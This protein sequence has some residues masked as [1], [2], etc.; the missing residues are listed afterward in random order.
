[1]LAKLTDTIGLELMTKVA[2]VEDNATLRKYLAE[3]INN[4]PGLR[5][6]CACVSAEEALIEIPAHKPNVVL[7]DIHLPG[8]SGI[9]CTARLREKLPNLQ[10]IM[11]TVYKD[12]KMIF[13]ALKAGACG[14]V[15]KRSD[16]KEI[17]A[18]IAEV[19][20]GGAP[21]TSEIARMVVRSFM[22]SPKVSA[23]ETDQLS[24]REMEILA[25]VAEGY[26]NKEIASR[27]FISGATVRTHLMHIYEKLHV[28]CRTEAAA[29]YLR[30]NPAGSSKPA[31]ASG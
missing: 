11:L 2:I 20:A 12:I 29:K 13:Q 19:R 16:E 18:A 23:D 10:V 14:Y 3:M 24:T 27:L 17:L 22:E 8:E 15:L 30:S 5:C 21:M 26:P 25:L 6:V 28:H 7:M 1:M 31:R 9:A 4:T